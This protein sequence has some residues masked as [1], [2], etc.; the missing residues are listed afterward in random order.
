MPVT[1]EELIQISAQVGDTLAGIRLPREIARLY[2]QQARL[3]ASQPGLP[4][5]RREE[6]FSLL[7]DAARLIQGAFLKRDLGDQTWKRD[8]RRSGEILEWLSMPTILPEYIP[9]SFLAAAIYQLAGY[10]AR[11]LG[12]LNGGSLGS[13][14]SKAL[15]FFLKADFRLLQ[16]E[17]RQYW[18]REES[19]PARADESVQKIIGK[20]IVKQTMRS[21]GVISGWVRWG[22]DVRIEKALLKLQNVSSAMVHGS[23]AYSWLLSKLLAEIADHYLKVSLRRLLNEMSL[24]RTDVGKA[25]LE[26][27]VRFAFEANSALAWPSQR[28]GLARLAS[29]ESFALCTPTG[30]GKTRV[31]EMAIL[32]CLFPPS[33]PAQVEQIIP[34]AL[35]LVPSR[36]LAAEVETKLSRV[37]RQTGGETITVTSLYGGIDWGASDALLTFEQRTVVIATYEKTE[38]LVRFLGTS[39]VERVRLIVIDEAH[40]L[41]DGATGSELTQFASRALRLEVLAARLLSALEGR[42]CRVIALSAVARGIDSSLAQWVARSRDA[43]P[44]ET[45]YR[46]TRQLVGQLI[47][48][49]D[50][51]AQI[52]YDLLDGQRLAVRGLSREE[53]PYIQS[54]FPP[55]PFSPGFEGPEKSLRPQL[56]WAAIHMAA[57][58]SRGQFHSVLISVPQQP[59]GYAQDFL[60]LLEGPWTGVGIPAFF[61][62]PPDGEN[63]VW[64]R[65][66]KSCE[67]YFGTDSREYRLLSHGIVLHHGKMPG[68]MSRLLIELIQHRIVNLVIATST[69]TEGINLPFEVILIPSLRRRDG[70]MDAREVANLIGRAGRPGVSTE[71]RSLLLMPHQ[72]TQRVSQAYEQLLQ[73][74]SVSAFQEA[75]ADQ[76]QGPLAALLN[77]IKGKWELISATSSFE[78]FE[79]WLENAVLDPPGHVEEAFEALD[80]LDGILLAGIEEAGLEGN[81]PQQRLDLEDY[82]RRLWKNS[83]S[84]YSSTNQNIWERSL[85]V[86]GTALVDRIYPERNLRR[87]LYKTSLSPREGKRVIDQLPIFEGLFLQG[88][89]YFSW[90]SAERRT[91]VENL[92]EAMQ[93][94]PSFAIQAPSRNQDW[95]VL[96]HWWLDP[97]TALIR[98]TS[99]QVS[100]WYKYVEKNFIYKFTWGIGSM[101]ALRLDTAEVRESNFDTWSASGL[102]WSAYWIKDLVTWGLLDPVAVYLLMKGIADTRLEAITK[103]AVYWQEWREHESDEMF[104]PRNLAGWA[105][106]QSM[107]SL[108]A[109]SF[110]RQQ[111]PLDSQGV[112]YPVTIEQAFVTATQRQWKVL[113]IQTGDTISWLDQAGYLL[114]RGRKPEGWETID[115]KANDFLLDTDRSLVIKQAYL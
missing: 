69:L 51:T 7:S 68:L 36:A 41:I 64:N 61:I 93:S 98:P 91:Y 59:G 108:F 115:I 90:S 97:T 88:E 42:G 28:D 86:R 25:A 94:I 78:E 74:L 102:P 89:Q 35:Y 9:I 19:M 60:R 70:F 113:P 37:L 96:L 16:E 53:G 50:R 54:P 100:D 24:T 5:W 110:D 38:A 71:G 39:F 43:G 12:V 57:R 17:I 73:Q 62:R 65:C 66:L 109:E 83:F 107:Q 11:A 6:A 80:T 44:V 49:P 105:R 22:D 76:A 21:L 23:D 10:P 13:E 99:S 33:D 31:A 29:G 63:T 3:Q 106:M 81:T 101:L 20:T 111:V 14:F 58:D 27:Y 2:S 52:N 55:H 112:S 34:I 82:I 92:A 18:E 56:F 47:C 32:D 77:H 75:Q 104:D 48:R 40:N 95:R 45:S 1:P 46:S 85:V 103:A 87:Q 114:A 79:S 67:D 84:F 30:S 4:S 8:L 15:A 72:P 26:R